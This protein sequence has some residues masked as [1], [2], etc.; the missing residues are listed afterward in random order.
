MCPEQK[1]TSRNRRQD[2]VAAV[3]AAQSQRGVARTFGVSLLPVPRWLARAGDLPLEQVDWR[4]TSHSPHTIANKTA[5]SVEEQVLM[6]RTA[7]AQSSDLGEYGAQAIRRERLLGVAPTDPAGVS[8][9]PSV[10]TINRL[11]ARHGVFDVG[12]RVR[13]ARPPPGWYLPDVAARH[14]E[15]DPIPFK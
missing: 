4:D 8:S 13:R 1:R 2:R 12:K 6:L 14:Q 7:L 5:L 10:P 3:R 9:V 11:L 15:L